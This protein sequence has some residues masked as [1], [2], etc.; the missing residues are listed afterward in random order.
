MTAPAMGTGVAVPTGFGARVAA[1]T[2]CALHATRSTPVLGAGT[3]TAKVLI[4]GEAPGA[5][6]D[7]TGLPFVGRSGRLLRQLVL[8]EL[9]LEGEALTISNLVRCRPPG[10]ATPTTA[11]RRACWPFMVEQLAFLQPAVIIT[12]GNTATQQ[13][14]DTKEGITTLRGA[15]YSAHGAVVIPTYHPAAALRGGA[16]VV[17]ALRSDLRL[18]RP[19]LAGTSA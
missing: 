15:T 12:V 7:R 10:N 18:A 2:A 1:C 9:G 3:G 6:E 17:E 8:D 16:V 11:Q 5:D 19:Y 13:I 14:L 4:L